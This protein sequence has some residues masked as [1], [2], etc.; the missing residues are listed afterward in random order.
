MAGHHWREAAVL[1]HTA[2]QPS[3]DDRRTVRRMEGHR[4]GRAVRGDHLDER[5]P[6]GTG[7]KAPTGVFHFEALMS[8]TLGAELGGAAAGAGVASTVAALDD[9]KE[10]LVVGEDVGLAGVVRSVGLGI[11]G[12]ALVAD[13]LGGCPGAPGWL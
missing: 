7:A 10:E 12:I 2:R 11:E 6:F 3:D 13:A 9:D 5:A 4:N 8:T 1:I